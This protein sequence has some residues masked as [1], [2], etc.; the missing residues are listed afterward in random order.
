[1]AVAPGS[2]R[3]QLTAV[4]SIGE[5]G[6]VEKP[7]DERCQLVVCILIGFT[8]LTAAPL[9]AQARGSAARPAAAAADPH[10]PPKGLSG[11]A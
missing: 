3:C 7:M 9:P 5:V 4:C 6:E 2:V 11:D 1:M 8:T 10:T